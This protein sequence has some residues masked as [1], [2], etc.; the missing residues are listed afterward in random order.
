MK[1]IGEEIENYFDEYPIGMRYPGG[2]NPPE[3]RI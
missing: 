2:S 3:M 1:E